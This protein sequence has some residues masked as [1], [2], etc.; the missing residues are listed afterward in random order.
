MTTSTFS[1]ISKYLI[2]GSHKSIPNKTEIVGKQFTR[3]QHLPPVIVEMEILKYLSLKDLTKV[4]V[5]VCKDWKLLSDQPIKNLTKATLETISLGFSIY[6]DDQIKSLYIQRTTIKNRRAFEQ[7][8][9]TFRGHSP[10][11]Y[12]TFIG[13][14]YSQ[15]SLYVFFNK[16][17]TMFIKQISDEKKFDHTIQ[18]KLVNDEK[19]IEAQNFNNEIFIRTD[20]HFYFYPLKS[21]KSSPKSELTQFFFQSSPYIPIS[22]EFFEMAN[23]SFVCL[24]DENGR[25][26]NVNLANKLDE[27]VFKSDDKLGKVVCFKVSSQGIWFANTNNEIHFKT[28]TISAKVATLPDPIKSIQVLADS[29]AL[30]HTD[31]NNV[32]IIDVATNECIQV[33]GQYSLVTPFATG[34]LSLQENKIRYFENAKV[35][36]VFV[37][38]IE[39]VSFMQTTSD[40]SIIIGNR[41]VQK[42]I[43][44]ETKAKHSKAY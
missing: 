30:V 6:Q 8:I 36:R 38:T 34:F 27:E 3:I 2:T 41:Y 25:V 12:A 11:N 19:L 20:Q 31:K 16:D 39:N 28:K 9:N 35:V 32:F 21:D 24:C 26:I 14:Q 17:N 1:T 44:F 5:L 4:A 40:H 33:P 10:I 18:L 22:F 42:L 23:Q 13:A 29:R 43:S 15:Q 37:H 7:R